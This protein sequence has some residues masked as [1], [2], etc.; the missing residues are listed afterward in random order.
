MMVWELGGLFDKVNPELGNQ[1]GKVIE[2]GGEGGNSAM[3]HNALMGHGT[4][5]VALGHSTFAI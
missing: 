5:A 3:S 2:W 4:A 1:W